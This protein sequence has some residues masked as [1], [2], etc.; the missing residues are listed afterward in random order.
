MRGCEIVRV[1]PVVQVL[2]LVH[3]LAAPLLLVDATH[4]F[5]LPIRQLII[6]DGFLVL[7]PDRRLIVDVDIALD[8]ATGR[9]CGVDGMG[10]GRLNLAMSG[11]RLGTIILII[12][13]IKKLSNVG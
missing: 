6:R 3:V 9:L 1:P 13:Q 7:V 11:Y 8:V 5:R 10:E 4:V 2:Q 12:L